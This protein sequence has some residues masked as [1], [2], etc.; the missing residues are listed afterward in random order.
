MAITKKLSY[1]EES[2]VNHEGEEARVQILKSMT[3]K[4]VELLTSKYYTRFIEQ[5][6]V[7]GASQAEAEQFAIRRTQE[8]A[9]KLTMLR[10]KAIVERKMLPLQMLLFYSMNYCPEMC[11][12][13]CNPEQCEAPLDESS[14]SVFFDTLAKLTG[15]CILRKFTIESYISRISTTL[16][17]GRAEIGDVESHM[18]KPTTQP[19]RKK[20][21]V[22][23]RPNVVNQ[24]KQQ[25]R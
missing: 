19:I 21:R 13:H 4:V 2:L 6:I 10:E 23:K 14:Q 18:W 17:T 5:M 9:A 24:N 16:K 8:I 12:W 22:R 11:D 20:L 3:D 25:R 7:N 15:M 1:L